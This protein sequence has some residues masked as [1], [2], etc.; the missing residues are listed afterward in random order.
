MPQMM[1][2]L[3][4]HAKRHVIGLTETGMNNR[5]LLNAMPWPVCLQRRF[6]NGPVPSSKL[7]GWISSNKDI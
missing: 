1:K 5:D 2:R 4:G 7:N 6:E 3:K